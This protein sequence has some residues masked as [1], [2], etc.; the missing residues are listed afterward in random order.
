METF[1]CYACDVRI[2][3]VMNV[4]ELGKKGEKRKTRGRKTA[5]MK[6]EKVKERVGNRARNV[7]KTEVR[8]NSIQEIIMQ[9]HGVGLQCNCIPICMVKH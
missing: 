9:R 3:E 5:G 1:I 7:W 4:Y 6:D 8:L 2:W